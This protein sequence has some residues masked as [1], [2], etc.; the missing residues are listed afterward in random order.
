M[1]RRYAR[2]YL[3]QF[4]TRQRVFSFRAIAVKRRA[5]FRNVA[6]TIKAS[7]HQQFAFVL[8]ER[9]NIVATRPRLLLSAP[10]RFAEPDWRD[11][12]PDRVARHR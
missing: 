2:Q 8:A 10:S 7:E 4:V 9:I 3:S 12:R 11:T 1:Q 6:K 5:G